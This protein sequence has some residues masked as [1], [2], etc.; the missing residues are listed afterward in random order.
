MLQ[1]MGLQRI[2]HSLLIKQEQTGKSVYNPLL[3]STKNGRSGS[4]LQIC[5]ILAVVTSACIFG[6]ISKFFPCLFFMGFLLEYCFASG[7][8]FHSE[9]VEIQSGDSFN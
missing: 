2:T 9:G 5:D 7:S 1:S 6:S 3:R 4:V 8:Q